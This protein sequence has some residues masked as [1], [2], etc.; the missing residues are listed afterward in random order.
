M[1]GTSEVHAQISG[2]YMHLITSR[3]M[4]KEEH[5]RYNQKQQNA[6]RKI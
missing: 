1:T 3:A 4:N 2:F 6:W 5:R